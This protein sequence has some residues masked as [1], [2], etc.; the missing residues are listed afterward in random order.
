MIADGCAVEID[1]DP[2]LVLQR[3]LQA[4][5]CSFDLLD[6]T[7]QKRRLR[8]HGFAELLFRFGQRSLGRHH[9]G[10]LVLVSQRVS[11]D[12]CF[13]L[14]N[15]APCIHDH[16]GGRDTRNREQRVDIIANL[17]DLPELSF[18]TNLISLCS[19]HFTIYVLQIVLY[20][21]APRSAS[22]SAGALL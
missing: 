22:A 9:F 5:L 7:A 17:I 10:V 11:G 19:G 18:E 21:A 16:W 1:R 8:Q 15:T 20:Q 12:P 14:N 13:H 2:L 3:P 4:G 6:G